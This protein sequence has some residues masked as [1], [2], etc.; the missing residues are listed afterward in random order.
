MRQYT[1]ERRTGNRTGRETD[2]ATG[3]E[4]GGAN[5]RTGAAT[6]VG[7][8]L[9]LVAGWLVYRRLNRESRGSRSDDEES[10]PERITIRRAVTVGA[11]ADDLYEFWRDPERLTRIAGEVAEVAA[12][13]DER[14]RWTLAAPLGLTVG[15]ETEIL[16]DRP[17]EVLR[18]RSEAGALVPHEASVRF[19]PAPAD[20]GTEVTLELLVD[21]PGGSAGAKA[22]DLLGVVP[23]TLA[24]KALYRFK[25]LAETGEIPT[26]ERNPSA[27]GRG[28]WV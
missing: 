18:W 9:A 7:G 22:L 4:T 19:R 13:G 14:H 11:P 12:A 6:L 17:G 3:S 25:S 2:D 23:E 24:S 1:T 26:L 27:R 8:A 5:A 16:E 20:R 10:A 28:D 15:W 21:P